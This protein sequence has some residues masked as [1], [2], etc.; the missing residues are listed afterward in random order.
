M[1]ILIADDHE[2][3]RNGVRS[4]L[5][6]DPEC[7]ICGEAI[8]GR[9]AVT[10]A[11]DLKPD[12][13]VM[14]ISMPNLN[15]LDATRKV[16]EILP[17][18]QVLVLSQH[19][20]PEMMRQALKAGAGAYV[21]KSS[22]STDLLAGIRRL[23]HG[24]AFFEPKI[25]AHTNKPPDERT[26]LQRAMAFEKELAESEERF[27]LTFE[28]AAVGMALV[29]ED[30]HFLRAND[31]LCGIVGYTQKELRGMTFQEITHPADLS[32]DLAQAARVASGEIDQYF[33]EKRYIRKDRSTVWVNLTVSAVRA[34]DSKIKYFIAVV[35]DI[36]ARKA[37]EEQLFQ[38]QLEL[39]N[40][41]ASRQEEARALAKLND[42][43][44]R[45]L[46]TSNL[47][48]GL[49]S[50]L[51]GVMETLGADKGNVQ[52]IEPGRGTLY[53]AAQCGFQEDFLSF[54]REVCAVDQSSCGRAL[55]SGERVIIEDIEH[56]DAYAELRDV[57]RAA[58]YRAVISVPLLDVDGKPLGMLSTH[59]RS[60]HRPSADSLRRLDL[61]A[62]QAASFIQRCKAEAALRESE[63]RFR[64]LSE[65]LETLHAQAELQLTQ[66]QQLFTNAPAGLALLHGPE[67]RFTFVNSECLR[68]SRRAAIE[69]LVG[70]PAREA[71]PEL[72]SQGYLDMLDRV[73]RTGV[74]YVGTENPVLIET[75]EGK[76]QQIY[77]DFTIQPVR[78]ASG[79][80]EGL[81]YHGV[82]VTAQV[83][84]RQAVESSEQRLR[85]SQAAAGIGSWEWDPVHLAV[86]S[87][88]LHEIFGTHQDDT[89]FTQWR[90]RVHPEDRERVFRL[91]DEGYRSGEI[92]FEYR[93]VH[94][95]KG[96]RWF[97]SKGRRIGNQERMF[98]VVIDVTELK[99]T[100]EALQKSEQAQY[101]LAA[102]V[103]SSDDAIVSKNLDGLITSWNA[104]AERMLGY[105]AE[106]AIGQ[107]IMIVIPPHLHEHE[108][109]IIAKLAAGQ[110]VEHEETIRLRKDGSVIDVSVTISPVRDSDGRIVGASNVT[111]DITVRKKAEEAIKE[112][113]FSGRLLQMQDQE[114]RHIA[115]ELHDSMGQLAAGIS[116]SASRMAREQSNFSPTS[117]KSL[118][119][120]S[121]LAEHLSNEI[122]TIS[123]LLHPPM[124]DEMGLLSALAW[125][126]EGFAER[127]NVDVKL[128][129]PAK[130]ERLPQDYELTLFRIVQESLTNI[131]RHSGSS[132]ALIRLSRTCSEILLEIRDQGHGINEETK[133]RLSS[134]ESAG[135][136]LRGMRERVR[137]VGGT[138][139]IDSDQNGTSVAACLP[140]HGSHPDPQN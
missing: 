47:Q 140:L 2:I 11:Q 8:D 125:Y 51:G 121:E 98:G 129:I 73:Y 117:V 91:M 110:R 20:S 89:L 94:P 127:S 78:N 58:G 79:Q 85:L 100:E 123:Y 19:D 67:H 108:K 133:S 81:L 122:R 39:A 74:E 59:F 118:A 131:H 68:T 9:D 88:E 83:A 23:R 44:S 24:E 27:R 105:T 33:L 116:I 130:M 60:P 4:L 104:A 97:R 101:Q 112:R 80:I 7:E 40:T 70:K 109:E 38:T 135:V 82:E 25:A 75:P 49:F 55:T 5:S 113:E 90:S 103:A 17:Q 45:L 64:G 3:V 111:R 34:S 96:L 61:Y 76:S 12:L 29:S 115:R 54:F 66:L 57:A 46:R 134:G 10:K 124:L 6:A 114:R 31:K 63:A 95:V 13:V 84:A 53:I 62:R 37:A 137:S 36:S 52:L 136:G 43:T 119:E 120:I 138:L 21:R 50:M 18:T 15:G 32:P 128:E 92:D 72:V 65:R 48:E 28:Q 139:K 102:I 22:M 30:G 99:R 87:D 41:A 42:W 106:E 56:D 126:V 16:R 93:F 35:E 71:I 107:S 26:I 132:T 86:L 77:I 1:R 69:N 14:D